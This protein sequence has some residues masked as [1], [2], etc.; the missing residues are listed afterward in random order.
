MY[1]P[2]KNISWETLE[3]GRIQLNIPNKVD[4]KPLIL[5]LC[6]SDQQVV[7]QDGRVLDRAGRPVDALDE[8]DRP[9]MKGAVVT[10]FF[11]AAGKYVSS[12]TKPMPVQFVP[13]N[14][15]ED[16]FNPLFAEW[17]DWYSKAGPFTEGTLVKYQDPTL[18]LWCWQVADL[19]GTLRLIAQTWPQYVACVTVDPDDRASWAA[20]AN[21][22][23]TNWRHNLALEDGQGNFVGFACDEGFTGKVLTIPE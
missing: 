7:S 13:T 22:A 5:D 10:N 16:P 3:D 11:D 19:N 12:C 6:C 20:T 1:G 15:F 21:A 17:D 14:V 8:L 4:C 18:E 2:Q 23:K 9:I